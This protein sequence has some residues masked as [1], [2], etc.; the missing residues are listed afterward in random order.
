M[1]CADNEVKYTVTKA[2]ESLAIRVDR[3]FESTAAH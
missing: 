2:N 3:H 1:F